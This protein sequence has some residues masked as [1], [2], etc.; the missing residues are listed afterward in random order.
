MKTY[1]HPYSTHPFAMH[2]ASAAARC[3]TLHASALAPLTV[4]VLAIQG[5]FAEHMQALERHS[6]VKAIEVS[7]QNKDVNARTPTNTFRPS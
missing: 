7:T 5:S 4:G 2:H 6:N 1:L 3:A